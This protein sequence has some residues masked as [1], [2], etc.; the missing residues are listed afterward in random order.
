M[1]RER[2]SARRAG[3][4]GAW[5]LWLVGLGWVVW[6]VASS[7]FAA[8]LWVQSYVGYCFREPNDSPMGLGYFSWWPFGAGCD[9]Y[10]DPDQPPGLPWTLGLLAIIVGAVLLARWT[11]RAVHTDGHDEHEGST[12]R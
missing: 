4:G 11:H 6:V 2:D 3:S 12:R 9:F 8:L 10:T 1:G 5:S 7:A